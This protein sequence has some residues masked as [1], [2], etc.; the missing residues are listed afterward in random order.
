MLPSFRDMKATYW[1]RDRG[2]KFQTID[3]GNAAVKIY[4]RSRGKGNARRWI[5]EV[6]DYTRGPGARRLRGFGEYARAH[7]EA[8]RIAGQLATGKT[9]AA[10]MLGTEAASYG[11]ASELLRP[12][13]ASLE[14]AAATYAK[15]F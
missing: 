2:E 14:L 10:A 12:T 7:A 8:K 1:K 3:E 15:A 4:R 5:Y 9:T 13:G 6:C 11:R